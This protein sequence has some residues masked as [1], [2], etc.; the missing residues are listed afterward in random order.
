[1]ADAA[2]VGHVPDCLD[3]LDAAPLHCAGVTTYT[4]VKV[5]GA[6]PSD[7]VAVYG[8]G[9]LGHLALQYANIAGASVAAADVIDSK[10]QLARE[11]GEE[12]T[13]NARRQ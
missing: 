12:H 5:S 11:L 7:L 6:R 9:G 2:F 8:I 3:P 1:V 13:V 4:A 10:L